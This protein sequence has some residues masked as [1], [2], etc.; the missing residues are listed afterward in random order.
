M[1]FEQMII[2]EAFRLGKKQVGGTVM[3]NQIPLN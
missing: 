2:N 1:E 3:P